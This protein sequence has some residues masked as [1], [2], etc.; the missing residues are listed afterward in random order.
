MIRLNVQPSDFPIVRL[1]YLPD[2]VLQP[3]PHWPHQH[4]APPL[5]TPNEVVNHQMD[6]VLLMFI[7]HVDK[8]PQG[9]TGH[10]AAGPFIPY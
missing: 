8:I 1:G 10:K 4:L 7:V 3:V 6:A 9:N 5:G 2:D